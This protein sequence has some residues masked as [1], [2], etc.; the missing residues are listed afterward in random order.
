MVD[1]GLSAVKYIYEKLAID[2]EWSQWYERGFVWWGYQLAQNV[3]AEPCIEVEGYV[4]CRIHVRTDLL[5][6]FSGSDEQLIELIPMTYLST[7]SGPMRA[8]SD[9]T[10]IQLASNV[11]LHEDTKGWLQEVLATAAIMQAEEASLLVGE[12]ARLTGARPAFSPHPTTGSREDWDDILNVPKQLFIPAGVDPSRFLG[13][14]MLQ[15][16]EML[17]QPPCIRATGDK[18]GLCA[19]FPFGQLSSLLQMKTMEGHPRYGHGLMMQLEIPIPSS[20]DTD[21]GAAKMALKLNE[22]ERDDPRAFPHFLGSW[23]PGERAVCFVSFFPNWLFKV[24]INQA[25]AQVAMGRTKWAADSLLEAGWDFK[26][27]REF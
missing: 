6:D 17:Q 15:T 25:L 2:E 26:K 27:A 1:L 5:D 24:G 10:R 19:E 9:P 16:L 23:C 21:L 12:L 3:W 14:D 11:Y 13:H 4:F 18:D 22:M 8:P 7:L 20:G